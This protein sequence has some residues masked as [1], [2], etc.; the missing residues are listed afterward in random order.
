MLG[1]SSC[2]FCSAR[3]KSGRN[4]PWTLIGR[5]ARQEACEPAGSATSVLAPFTPA[6]SPQSGMTVT[7]ARQPLGAPK[8]A[9]YGYCFRRN[10]IVRSAGRPG[11]RQLRRLLS[12]TRP[13]RPIARLHHPRR[14][15][16]E[17]AHFPYH[18]LAPTYS[19]LKFLILKVLLT[20]F[21]SQLLFFALRFEMENSH[22]KKQLFL[23]VRCI[24]TNDIYITISTKATIF[25]IIQGIYNIVYSLLYRKQFS[26]LR[27]L[28]LSKL[29]KFYY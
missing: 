26:K 12:V 20:W 9:T 27:T 10:W 3:R 15:S 24:T 23:L 19:V 4:N 11:P 13:P 17:K 14:P 28:L 5:M 18:R 8:R 16:R 2:C 7:A 6:R 22:I 25:T 1:I 29:F 21:L